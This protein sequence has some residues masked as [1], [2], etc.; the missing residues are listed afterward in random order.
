MC[1]LIC[2]YTVAGADD[3]K[4]PDSGDMDLSTDIEPDQDP[5]PGPEIEDQLEEHSL[6]GRRPQHSW[7]HFIL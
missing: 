1:S 3:L 2:D 6:A 4:P 7:N 5:S